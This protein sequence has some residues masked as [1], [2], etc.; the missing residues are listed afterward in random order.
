MAYTTVAKV[1]SMFRNLKTD[2]TNSALTTAEIQIWIDE[3]SAAVV[4]CLSQFYTM[5]S[6]GSNSELI[7]SRIETFKVAGIVDD[8]LNNYAEAKSKPMYDKKGENLLQK[9]I[10]QYNTKK[11]EWCDP[12]AKLPDPP[13]IGLPSSTTEMSVQSQGPATFKKGVDAW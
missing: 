13:F 10:P 12:L 5:T 1:K 7:L 6:V 3:V 2:G 4:S 11:C 9:Y 8:M